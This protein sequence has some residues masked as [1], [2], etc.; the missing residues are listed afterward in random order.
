M[1]PHGIGGTDIAAVLGLSPYRTALEVWTRLVRCVEHN[2]DDGLHLRFGRHAE[3]FVAGE[4]ERATGLMT[5][6]HDGPLFH[7]EHRFMFGHV[8]RL[9]TKPGAGTAFEGGRVLTDRLLECKTASAYSRH[10]WGDEGTDRV[11]RAYLLQCAWYLSITGCQIADL[12]VL[13][14]NNDFRVYRI[15]R[16]TELE[17]L[18]QSHARR[19]W[20][21][22]VLPMVPPRPV[23]AG[24]AALL[25]PREVDG[26]S[27]EASPELL[28]TLER[29]RDLMAQGSALGSECERLRAEI[30]A[31]MGDA[32]ALT[33]GG[34]TLATWR[35]AR[36]A[37]RIDSHALRAALPDVA[38]RFSK[39]CAGSR[40]FLLRGAA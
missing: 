14:G 11:P 31:Y 13:L 26:A 21:D 8:D 34:Q 17:G 2:L 12:A 24:D 15:E 30:L 33:F 40:R 36:P 19:F 27:V 38:A 20:L 29:Y 23:T 37:T 9:V 28:Q 32:G 10:E 25:F 5:H 7:P 18:L 6:T 35:S 4:Y 3:S 1:R 39:E 16:D 22:H